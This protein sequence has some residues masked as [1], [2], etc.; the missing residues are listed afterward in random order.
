MLKSASAQCFVVSRVLSEQG[1]KENA[2]K[3]ECAV[4]CSIKSSNCSIKGSKWRGSSGG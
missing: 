1:A 3:Y 4:F 2:E